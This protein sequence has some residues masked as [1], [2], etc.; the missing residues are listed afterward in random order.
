MT[1]VYVQGDTILKE[2]VAQQAP[3]HGEAVTI[4]G[5]QFRV[6]DVQWLD[7]NPTVYVGQ[8]V[9]EIPTRG[10]KTLAGVG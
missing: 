3:R 8:Y 10:R 7:G 6:L 4:D 2:E 5:V 1:V 9:P